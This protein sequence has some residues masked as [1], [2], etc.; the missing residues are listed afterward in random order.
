MDVLKNDEREVSDVIEIHFEKQDLQQ[1]LKK[2]SK[3]ECKVLEMRYGIGNGL[4]RTQRD[5]AKVLGISRSYV[6]RIEKRAI[7]K[8]LEEF[9]RS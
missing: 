1:K 4:R 8:L 6:S 5:I 7:K 9:S 3:R 2:L